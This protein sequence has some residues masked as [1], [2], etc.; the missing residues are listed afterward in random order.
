MRS[1]VP[2]FGPAQSWARRLDRIRARH[3]AR[4]ALQGGLKVLGGAGALLWLGTLGEA[5]LWTPPL[6]RQLFWTLSAAAVAGWLSYGVL[7]P[8]LRR[9]GWLSAVSLEEL[10]RWVGRV[11]SEVGDR[12]VNLLQLGRGVPEEAS[13]ALWERALEQL[14]AR[15]RGVPI[16]AALDQPISARSWA[17]A[18]M[19]WALYGLALAGGPEPFS[20]AAF[21][22]LH[23]FAV[24]ERPQPFRWVVQPADAELV[25]GSPLAIVART[26]GAIAPR[27][28]LLELRPLGVVRSDTVWLSADSLGRFR[29][30]VPDVRAPLAYR[31]AAE[32]VRS[33]WF[34]AAVV[35]R[36]VVRQLSLRLIFPAY[37]ALPPQTLEPNAGEIVAPVGT[38]VLLEALT[39][40]AVVR[41][42]VRFASSRSLPLQAQ[43]SRLR[44]RFIVQQADT[45]WIWAQDERGLSTVDPIPYRILPVPDE[46]PQITVLSPEAD[47]RLTEAQRVPLR[48]RIADDLGFLDLR[49]YYRRSA[50]SYGEA[51]SAWRAQELPI[52]RPKPTI[53]ELSWDWDLRP[54]DLVPGDVLEYYL[55]VR[56]NDRVSGPKAARTGL[57]TVRFPT[58]AERYAAAD[59]AQQGL[60]QALEALF[61][62]AQR[63]QQAYESFQRELRRKGEPS[64][65]DERRLEQLR[66][67]QEALQE[68]ALELA[69]Q[70]AALSQHLQENR[71]VSP[72]TLA[73]LEQLRQV[74]E[75]IQDPE[76]QEALRRLQEAMERLSLPQI[77]QLLER[78]QINEAELRR[79]L[80]RTL[81]LLRQV[82]TLQQLD[83]IQ[84]R[85]EELARTEEALR[86][87]AAEIDPRDEAPRQ[88]LG[89]EQ[90]RA[91]DRAEALRQEM[92]RLEE[93]LR[94][95]RRERAADEV[96]RQQRGLES[97]PDEMRQNAEELRR[98][99]LDR[100]ASE[101]ERL[102]ERFRQLAEQM[103]QLSQQL[104]AQQQ[105]L[106]AAALR[107]VLDE[108]LA[109]SQRQEA[110]RRQLNPEAQSASLLRAQAR[111]QEQIRRHFSRV[112]DSLSALSRRVP[113]MNETVLRRS[114]ETQAEMARAIEA[115]SEL[116]AA[117]A[118]GYQRGAMKGLNDLAL[119]LADVLG[120]VQAGQ[121]AGMLSMPQLIEQLQQMAEQQARL[122]QQIQEL[123]N[124]LQQGRL[125]VD[126]QQRLE[127]MAL[128]QEMIRRQIEQM[129]RQERRSGARELL[130]N[131]DQIA[132][133]M[134]ETIRELLENQLDRQTVRRQQQ[135][136]QRLLD[137]QRSIRE[138]DEEPRRQGRTAQTPPDRET[139]PPLRL[140]ELQD[141]LQRDLLR[142]LE[143]GYAPDYEAL[144]R[145]YFEQLQKRPP[146]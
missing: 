76:F 46:P 108:V 92:S 15:L 19:P 104:Q 21:R 52:E 3:Y 141:R 88:R 45:Y 138:R 80:E 137:A 98:G 53:Q 117:E 47:F 42:E 103:A 61:S 82:Q 107:R 95:L 1:G 60:E 17:A 71:L 8:L 118:I 77:Q 11:Q 32:G 99:N 131:L 55:E 37:M 89:Q 113:E 64:W 79:R 126:L 91:A 66:Q 63:F 143:A 130:G 74:L 30:T 90:E 121:A 100:A 109:L 124:Q 67:E 16:E 85:A 112:A 105:Q 136:L 86:R 65:E 9:A 119:M 128:Q 83:E 72:E 123:L 36:P 56:D 146:R 22:L 135:I 31:L 48:V 62:R 34:T 78:V 50:S 40:K 132:R 94:Q 39:N 13:R 69:Q 25:R 54:L 38:Q 114:R 23:P 139:P 58:L 20:Q 35:D 111:E 81:E 73:R 129:A 43:G 28:A 24:F 51:D 106:N 93:R 27:R 75:E 49:L 7:I 125:P 101:L 96:Q 12:L 120:Q 44:G 5:L 57:L 33:R 10:A 134:Q 87:Q 2:F 41:A 26:E 115:L 29:Y 116:R 4:Q 59:A 68:Q 110:L 127:Q 142:A 102:E 14:D 145:R 84:R 97:A 122:N 140:P 144:I 133:Q 6:L 18:L 70:A